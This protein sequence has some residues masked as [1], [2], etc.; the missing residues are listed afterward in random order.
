MKY[1]DDPAGSHGGELGLDWA[2]GPTGLEEAYAWDPAAILPG[3]R[4][5][6]ILGVEA[7]VWTETIAAAADLE[8]MVFPRIAA[9]AEIAWS[10]SV[11]AGG[12]RAADFTER[13][14]ALGT[15]L[16]ALGVAYHRVGGVPWAEQRRALA[17]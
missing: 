1:P 8:F 12:S 15:H 16:D 6:D 14:A 9:I 3:L 17:E 11:I 10:P 5:S 13:L 2:K 4:E 7:P